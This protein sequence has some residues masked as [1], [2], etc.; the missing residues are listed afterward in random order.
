LDRIGGH[1]DAPPRVQLE[2]LRRLA[3]IQVLHLK[4]HDDAQRTA[5]R[6]SELVIDDEPALRAKLEIDILVKN[7]ASAIKTLDTL[8]TDFTAGERERV[9]DLLRLAALQDESLDDP[10]RAVDTLTRL[11]ELAGHQ[12]AVP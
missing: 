9:D 8:T 6:A 5:L 2:A 12:G 1:N 10:R 11:A 3:T 4:R 7:D